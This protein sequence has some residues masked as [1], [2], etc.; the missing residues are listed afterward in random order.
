LPNSY[1]VEQGRLIGGEY[2]GT[3]SRADTMER[4][5]RLLAAGVN[6]FLDLTEPGETSPYDQLLPH[7]SR[8][9]RLGVLYARKPIPDHSVPAAPELMAEILDYLDRALAAGHCVY[10][11]CRAGVGRT[12]T[13]LGCYL[14]HRGMAPDAAL[15]H[16]NELW[17]A[18]ERSE[19]WPTTPETDEQEDFVRSWRPAP[20]TA[21]A[22][23]DDDLAAARTLRDR[24][25]G[26]LVGL[27]VG[28]ALGAA[29]QHRKP[30]S[31]TA[32][33]DLLGGGP[34]ELP[35]GAWTDDT[36][37]ALCL[38]ESLS[39]REEFDPS[40]Q[41]ERYQRWQR[42]GYLT[43]TGECVGI[44]AGV[45][46][47]LATARWSGKPFAGSHD[48]GQLDKEPL[49]RLAPAVMFFL[50]EPREAIHY[51]AESARITQQ[52]P[53]VLDACRYLAALMAGALRGVGRQELLAPRYS[54]V[55]GLWDERGLKE[56]V[57]A[58]ALGSYRRKAAADLDG[59]GNILQTLEAVLW[60][61]DHSTSFREGALL[62][63]NLGLD[64]DVTGA[65]YGQ[66]AGAL[67]G[68]AGIP[69]NW[70]SALLKRDLIEGLA[71]RLL[72]RALERMAQ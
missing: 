40:D 58:I 53:I 60:A 66:L 33:A 67:Y 72:A 52:S 8:P 54:P 49:S 55:P 69:A 51:A 24:F 12:G 70:R 32:V 43:S 38:A 3:A 57:E 41:V 28:D 14:V 64:A 35:R 29:I 47:A 18:N 9:G 61:L 21:S 65:V 17:R 42:A 11:H 6:Y 71:D 45:S 26:A 36:A 44:T 2:P 22:V 63:V 7:E 25:R 62:A 20:A 15:Q 39:E 50:P 48:P 34:F 31:F 56:P 30:G 27:A 19:A 13:V 59:G 46:K 10:V 16:L 23:P 37:M 4:L 1:W 68:L 5:R